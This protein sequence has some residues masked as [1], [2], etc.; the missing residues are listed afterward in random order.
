MTTI[1]GQDKKVIVARK[2]PDIAEIQVQTNSERTSCWTTHYPDSLIQSVLDLKGPSHLIDEIMR[3]EC[4]DYV[5]RALHWGLFSFVDPRNFDAKRLLDFGC[6]AGAS[7]S[8]LSRWLPNT[9]FVG[10]D[11]DNNFLSVA[12]KRAEY[13]GFSDRSTFL[14]SP[15]SKALPD[16]GRFDFILLSAVFEH[17]LPEERDPLLELTWNALD[18][19]GILFLN[20]TPN[21]RALIEYH[22][23][24]G[25]PLLN[26]FPDR[27]A[28]FYATRFSKRKL[29]GQTWNELL[30]RGIRGATKHELSQRLDRFAKGEYEF[31]EVNHPEVS[32]DVELWYRSTS[33]LDQKSIKIK[34]IIKT[35]AKFAGPL[36]NL[37]LPTIILAIRK[38]S[39]DK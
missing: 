2:K 16:T 18:V 7:T 1:N 11:L 25:L 15:D 5:Q 17:L 6:G 28:H 24:L 9:E 36:R 38:K 26:Y 33:I 14:L 8:I 35:A 34:N 29:Q 27:L 23:T 19:N 13:Y 3:D 32:N 31:L 21:Q 12:R 22:T 37:I 20:Q 10:V 30:R 39:S 4:A